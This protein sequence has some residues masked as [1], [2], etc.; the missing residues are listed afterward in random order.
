MIEE[1][2]GQRRRR[3]RG[4]GKGYGHGGFFTSNKSSSSLAKPQDSWLKKPDNSLLPFVHKTASASTEKATLVTNGNEQLVD[5]REANLLERAQKLGYGKK[6]TSSS[7]FRHP[8]NNVIR[9]LTYPA[10]MIQCDQA[11]VSSQGPREERRRRRKKC[12]PNE[13]P[14]KKE[15]RQHSA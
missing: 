9:N 2:S 4:K 7:A 1:D 11:P 10:W 13:E 14:T 8:L 5:E 15:A 3:G 12:E 6:G